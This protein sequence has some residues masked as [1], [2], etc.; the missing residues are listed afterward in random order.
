MHT[1]DH[2]FPNRRSRGLNSRIPAQGSFVVLS[3]HFRCSQPAGHRPP[4][5]T[6]RDDVAVK[7]GQLEVGNGGGTVWSQLS[8]HLAPHLRWRGEAEGA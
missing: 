5:L 1:V 8:R 2:S 6:R 3:T 7:G 4:R